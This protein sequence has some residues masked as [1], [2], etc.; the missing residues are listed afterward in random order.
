MDI[1]FLINKFYEGVSTPEEERFLTDYFLNEK[2]I[3]ERW[4]GEQK[5]FLLLRESQI[6]VPQEISE[7]LEKSI[8][9]METVEKPQPRKRALFYWI[10][11]AAAVAV[12]CIGFYFTNREPFTPKMVDTFSNPEE[13]AL[14]AEQTLTFMSLHL[15]NGL[16]K[17]SDVG[18]EFEKVNQLINKHLNN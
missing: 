15:N 13:A 4:K 2:N 7:R 17:V 9:Q 18:M 5:L 10:S 1:E 11:S 16:N 3:D 14:V 8:M 6:K 12:L